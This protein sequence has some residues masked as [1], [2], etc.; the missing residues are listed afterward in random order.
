MQDL[1]KISHSFFPDIQRMLSCRA[2]YNIFPIARETTLFPK[3]SENITNTECYDTKKHEE[4]I[5]RLRF[6]WENT[7]N[8][9]RKF[10]LQNPIYAKIKFK[11]ITTKT[12]MKTLVRTDLLTRSWSFCIGSGSPSLPQ[13]RTSRLS[14][15]RMIRSAEFT[16]KHLDKWP[17][18]ISYF[19][20]QSLDKQIFS[21]D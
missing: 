3:G 19:I 9:V 1:D 18:R 11:N 7:H 17:H 12:N 2:S 13:V 15:T 6:L 14:Y 20:Y 10:I 21:I 5:Q 16:R 8:N 4:F